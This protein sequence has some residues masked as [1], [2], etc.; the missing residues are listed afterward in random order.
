MMAFLLGFLGVIL[1]L[2]VVAFL[3]YFFVSRALSKYGINK[4]DLVNMKEQLENE[5]ANRHKQ[6]SGMTSIYLPQIE[7]DIK[8]FNLDEMYL[9]TEKSLRTIFKAI[10]NKDISFLEDKDFNLIN[11]KLKLQMQ[12]LIDSDIIYKYD[13][14]IFHKHAIKNYSKSN[15]VYKIVISSSLEYYYKKSKDGKDITKK[16]HKV[17]T[18]YDT[19]FVYITDEAAYE[20]DINIYGLNCPNCGAVIKSIETKKCSY[21]HTGLNIEVIDLLKCWKII[22]Y[23]KIN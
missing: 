22:D 11:K 2:L 8:N 9:L 21:C 14:V 20:K 23:N 19:T 16:D 7:K 4:D 17:Q 12:N 18:S 3:I 1:G 10:S 13:D 6:I 15:G 5:E